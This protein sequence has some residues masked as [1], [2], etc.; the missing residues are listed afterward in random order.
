MASESGSL[1]KY[2]SSGT[3][4][5]RRP[6]TVRSLPPSAVPAA[7]TPAV[8]DSAARVL[9]ISAHAASVRASVSVTVA[10]PPSARVHDVRARGSSPDNQC[11]AAKH[12][13]KDA[14]RTA[15]TCDRCTT[16]SARQPADTHR[17]IPAE[18]GGR[19]RT[20]QGGCRDSPEATGGADPW[21]R[22]DSRAGARSFL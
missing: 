12:R 11:P 5:I 15:A 20:Y 9:T 2:A 8:S 4:R 6:S 21:P 14:V 3:H 16:P 18:Q 1:T 13:A 22:A 17:L 7:I 19:T 10:P